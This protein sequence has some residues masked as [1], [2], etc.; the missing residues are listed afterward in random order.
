MN[1]TAQATQEADVS[2]DVTTVND[3]DNNACTFRLDY[4]LSPV[5]LLPVLVLTMAEAS[6]RCFMTQD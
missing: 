6:P 1:R 4:S 5:S 3:D 2:L